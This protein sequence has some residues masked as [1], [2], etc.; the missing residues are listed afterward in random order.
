MAKPPLPEPVVELLRR[1]NPSVVA[2]LTPSGAPMAVPT[3]YLLED[4]GT[5][6]LNMDAERARLRWMRERPQVSLSVLKDGEWYT[7]VSMRGTIVR[8]EDDAERAHAD[9]DRLSQHYT[10]RP[11]PDRERPRVSAWLEV[12]TWHGWGAAKSD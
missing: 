12:E 1:P 10:G 7:H 2:S 8:W 3:W 11:Y 4:D 5:I 9:I 6:L